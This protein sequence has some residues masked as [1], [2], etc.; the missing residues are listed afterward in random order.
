MRRRQLAGQRLGQAT[1]RRLDQQG[2]AAAANFQ[3]HFLAR[4]ERLHFLDDRAQL[5]DRLAVDRANLV[6]RLELDGRGRTF[7]IDVA[8]DQ[9][10]DFSSD[11][12]RIGRMPRN[13]NS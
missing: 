6:A 5:V 10:G 12:P 4:L 8:H 9:A 13:G 11:S 3:L 2:F 1:Q 7:G